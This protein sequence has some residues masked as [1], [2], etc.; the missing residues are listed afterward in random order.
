MNKQICNVSID[1]FIDSHYSCYLRDNPIILPWVKNNMEP[2]FSSRSKS[3]LEI[4]TD[5]PAYSTALEM[6]G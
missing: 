3:Y 1:C 6:T 5:R 4:D 2:S